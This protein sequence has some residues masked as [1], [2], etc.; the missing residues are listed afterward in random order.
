MWSGMYAINNLYKY[1]CLLIFLHKYVHGFTSFQEVM[2][3]LERTSVFWKEGIL[4]WGKEYIYLVL[5]LENHCL[6]F[7]KFCRNVGWSS[8][9][10]LSVVLWCYF[11]LHIFIVQKWR[12]ATSIQPSLNLRHNGHLCILTMLLLLLIAIL[13]AYFEKL[14]FYFYFNQSS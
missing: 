10:V 6:P 11:A 8:R 3:Q 12:W 13:F 14:L 4:G 2:C 1:V 9:L 7:L 5:M